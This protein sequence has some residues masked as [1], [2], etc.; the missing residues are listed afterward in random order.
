MEDAFKDRTPEFRQVDQP[1]LV[2]RVAPSENMLSASIERINHDIIPIIEQEAKAAA[3]RANLL[4]VAFAPLLEIVHK[5]R[6]AVSARQ[7]LYRLASDR[8]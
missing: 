7:T 6:A 2:R 5:D 8:A 4:N 1:S 3:E